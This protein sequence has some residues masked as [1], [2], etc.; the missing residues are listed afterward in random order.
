MRKKLFVSI[1]LLG[2]GFGVYAKDVTKLKTPRDLLNDARFLQNDVKLM[3]E[4]WV[5]SL[6]KKRKEW[7]R[8]EETNTI[9][10]K[11][12]EDTE[13]RNK[14]R[15]RRITKVELH[16]D[17]YR[18]EKRV[19]NGNADSYFN[20]QISYGIKIK[21]ALIAG[22][23]LIDIPSFVGTPKTL[24]WAVA[25]DRDREK[26]KDL[27]ALGADTE[28]WFDPDSPALRTAVNVIWSKNLNNYEQMLSIIYYLLKYGAKIHDDTGWNNLTQAIMIDRI[29]GT[30]ALTKLFLAN[31]ANVNLSADNENL[32]SGSV[33]SGWFTSLY[34]AV[35]G[36]NIE[37]VKLIVESG[38]D[39]NRY[40]A[41][42]F[43][44]LDEIYYQLHRE[45]KPYQQKYEPSP[46]DR[47][48]LLSIRD[49]LISKGAKYRIKSNKR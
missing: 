22:K 39:L 31:G 47:V 26:V 23:P 34:P 4:R 3:E 43:T 21:K 11:N 10:R 14:E 30:T 25:V 49:Y 17:R 45:Y 18:H 37:I 40:N 16:I 27:L 46:T 41:G 29:R 13:V 6:K 42:G 38:V 15:Q 35:Y 32:S 9:Y 2:M 20:E 33:C 1:I 19:G 7:I 48:H 12:T 8:W 28:N 36:T 44:A 5:K 24:G